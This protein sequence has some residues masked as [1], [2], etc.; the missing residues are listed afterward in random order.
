MLIKFLSKDS[1][2]ISVPLSNP[3][4]KDI[5]LTAFIEGQYLEGDN[6]IS[7]TSKSK[8]KYD[9][10]FN[11]KRIGNY[12]GRYESFNLFN[13]T[14]KIVTHKFSFSLKF[15]SNE[16]GE[17]WYDLR[18]ASLDPLTVNLPNIQCEVGRYI[19]DVIKL[20]NPLFETITFQASSSNTNNFVLELPQKNSII[21]PA[22]TI[23]EVPIIF[24]P[25]TVGKSEHFTELIFYN[26]K[27]SQ[28]L[29]LKKKKL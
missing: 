10:K 23:T 29:F 15:I 7:I 28:T 5:E 20:Q 12:K 13:L 26:E 25:S 3:F 1:C 11:P 2:T 21:V 27:V 8:S 24:T 6:K 17:F 22:N 18:M 19:R 14:H 16:T 4:D 9:L